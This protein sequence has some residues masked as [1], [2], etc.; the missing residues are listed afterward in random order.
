V[1]GENRI[2]LYSW[3]LSRCDPAVPF[4]NDPK[5]LYYTPLSKEDIRWNFEK[6]L[7]D[8]AGQPYRRY[9]PTVEPT[10]MVED[11]EYLLSL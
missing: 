2:P 11:I 6:F 10:L 1:N 3:V 8:R 5:M 9:A 4:F 7:F